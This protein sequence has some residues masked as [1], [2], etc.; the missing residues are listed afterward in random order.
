MQSNHAQSHTDLRCGKPDSIFCIHRLNQLFPELADFIVN[1]LNR[2]RLH[3]QNPV[4]ERP[5]GHH[6]LFAYIKHHFTSNYCAAGSASVFLIRTAHAA[7]PITAAVSYILP[8]TVT[9]V[10][11]TRNG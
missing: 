5:D 6:F 7:V 8:P 4:P 2:L 11:A 3:M 1:F 9:P 10:T